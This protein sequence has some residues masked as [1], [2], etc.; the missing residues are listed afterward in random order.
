LFAAPQTDDHAETA[1][2]APSVHLFP[3]AG[4][5]NS[6]GTTPASGF[7]FDIPDLSFPSLGDDDQPGSKQE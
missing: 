7:G 3:D 2:P 4:E 1:T 5:E 6:H